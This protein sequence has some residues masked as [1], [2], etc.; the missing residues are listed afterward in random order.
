MRDF[1]HRF[2]F[3]IAVTAVM[4]A[5]DM[6]YHLATGWAVHLNYVAIKITVIF[7]SV[8]MITQF[9]GIG[10]Q[11]GV[12]ASI[13]SP[14]MFYIY[15][16]FAGATL[17]R[18]VFKIDEQ[19]WFFFLH[20]VL[21]GIAYFSAWNFLYS[22]NKRIKNVCFVITAGFMSIAFHALF[23]MVR[24][25]IAGLDEETAAS[26]FTL[27]ALLIPMIAYFVGIITGIL[28][29]T[30]FRRKIFGV[31][32][33]SLLPAGIIFIGTNELV[34]SFF[35]LLFVLLSCYIVYTFKKGLVV[36]HNE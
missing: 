22:G 17:N 35:A 27:S 12:V 29:E 28:S 33:T 5:L 6:I 32:V 21:M 10:K 19:F 11:E 26:V 16:V 20:A 36:V 13:F 4:N 30:F 25:R 2:L 9:I 3:A 23:L 34:A 15:Y 1:F 14:F 24:W 31:G 7:L 18:D 8:W